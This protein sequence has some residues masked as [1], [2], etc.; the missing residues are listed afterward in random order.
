MVGAY[1][2]AKSRTPQR[3]VLRTH[4]PLVTSSNLVVATIKSPPYT[5]E[6]F[7]ALHPDIAFGIRHLLIAI[8]ADLGVDADESADNQPHSTKDAES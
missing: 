2:S 1:G 4:K 6:S 7:L 8:G 3:V 5:G